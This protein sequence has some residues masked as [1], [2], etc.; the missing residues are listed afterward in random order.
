MSSPES[1]SNS[2]AHAPPRHPLEKFATSSEDDRLAMPFWFRATLATS[3]AAMFGFFLGAT[4]GGRMAALRFR[5]ENAH[6]LPT[7][8]VGWYLYHRSKNH[9]SIIG[10]LKGGIKAAAR[11]GLWVGM[12]YTVEEGVDH[13][14]K[15]TVGWEP[16]FLSSVAAGMSTASVFS[17]KNRFPVTTATRTLK[18]GVKVGLAYGVFQDLLRLSHGKNLSYVDFARN[19]RSRWRQRQEKKTLLSTQTDEHDRR[20][21]GGSGGTTPS[22]G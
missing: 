2:P 1:A 12:F 22:N 7:N 6:R 5:A 13:G 14:L 16:T 19:L 3:C 8:K 11:V 17:L 10:A 15:R 18:T 4:H 21:T 9:H 20:V